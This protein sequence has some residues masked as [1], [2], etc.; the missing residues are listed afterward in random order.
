MPNALEK[1]FAAAEKNNAQVVHVNG[2]YELYQDEP[3]PIRKKNLRIHWEN[4]Q[5]EGFL[6]PNPIYRLEEHWKKYN[7]W[8]MAWLNFCRRDFLTNSH[9]KFLPIISE[10][11]TFA[12]A[13]YCLTERYYIMREAFYV[14]R[15]RE[16]SIM[17][18]RS[19]EQISKAIQSIAIGSVYVK[20]LLNRLPRFPNYEQWR[21]GIMNEFFNRFT[22]NHTVPYYGS[23]QIGADVN[24]AVNDT[25]NNLFG[26]SASFAKYFFNGYH[27]FRRQAELLAAQNNQLKNFTATFI[28]EQSVLLELMASVRADGKRVLLMHTPRHGNIGDQAI[29]LG[30][31]RVLEKFFPEHKIIE[32]PTDYL[33]GNRGELL[34]A[35]GFEKYVRPD[36][37]IFLHGGGNLGNLWLGEEKIRREL[38]QRFAQNKIVSFPQ[39]I[40]FTDDD[41]GRAE[42]ATSQKIYGAHPDLHLMMRDENS[43]D[44]ATKNFPSAKNYLLPDSVTVLLGITDDC[45]D[46]RNGVLFVLRGDKE[47]IRDDKNISRLQ[48]Y[49]ADKNIPFTVTDTVIGGRVTSADREQKVREVLLKFRRSKLVVTDR[50]HGVIFSFVTRTPVLAFKSFDTK[51]SSG[52]R[53]FRNIPSIFYA[54]GQD[55]SR[56]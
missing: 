6:A 3:F 24:A 31:M 29:V 2:W 45:T 22:G 34:W 21:A 17:K 4:Y 9:I 30:E 1:F 32:V 11:E 54:E 52:I 56:M 44:F 42:L 50:F 47:K 7:T 48:K 27:S 14:Y 37:I 49:L 25:L 26:K 13:L 12:F 35:L 43:F 10:D 53:W 38:I 33:T 40:H 18:T 46:E 41:S 19:P 16:G 23:L 51:I 5:R 39:S 55:W 8:S 36:D 20:N 28:R 15:K